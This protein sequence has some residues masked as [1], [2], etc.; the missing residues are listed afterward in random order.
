MVRVNQEK[1]MNKMLGA[2][3]ENIENTNFSAV[4]TGIQGLL[5]RYGKD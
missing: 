4:K 5:K 1:E 3:D 2:I